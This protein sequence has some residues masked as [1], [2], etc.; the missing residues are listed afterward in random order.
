MAKFDYKKWVTENKYGKINEQAGTMC[1]A[2]QTPDGTGIYGK[3]PNPISAASINGGTIISTPLSTLQQQS[4]YTAMGGAVMNGSYIGDPNFT[5]I[6][7]GCGGGPAIGYFYDQAFVTGFCPSVGSGTTTTTTTPT[8]SATG[9]GAVTGSATG[10]GTTTTTTGSATG[11]ECFYCDPFVY[12]QTQQLTPYPGSQPHSNGILCTP[13]NVP[14]S[15][16]PNP[17]DNSNPGFTFPNQVQLV[18]PS[19]DGPS[20][21]YVK[22]TNMNI[23]CAAS[24]SVITSTGGPTQAGTGSFDDYGIGGGTQFNYPNNWSATGWTNNFVDM[25]LAHPNPCNFLNQRYNQFGNQLQQGGMGPLQ[26]NLTYQKFAVVHALLGLT[27]C[28]LPNPNPFTSLLQEQINEIK[29]DP[30]AKQILQK[31]EK[32]IRG[33]SRKKETGKRRRRNENKINT[34]KRIIKETLSELQ[35][36]QKACSCRNGVCKT[37]GGDLC[38]SHECGGACKGSERGRDRK[39]E[40]Y[41]VGKDYCVVDGDGI[42]GPL[43]DCSGGCPCK[44]GCVCIN[45]DTGYPKGMVMAKDRSMGKLKRIKG[46]MVYYREKRIMRETKGCTSC[47][48]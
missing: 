6:S 28:G 1:Y 13:N 36:K 27:G 5:G 44:A 46:K 12:A 26:T 2:C 17:F 3:S 22:W 42:E 47:N 19:M 30:A 18:H 10:S 4:G 32:E 43:P 16:L 23:G 37:A 35:E 25:M 38:P 14:I 41:N 34:L 20:S 11:S 8:G 21:T 24:A 9:S 39:D 33:L 15:S 45:K 31:R 7:S 40:L 29:L 48:K